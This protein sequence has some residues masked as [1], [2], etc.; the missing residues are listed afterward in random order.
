MI[1]ASTY[2]SHNTW[3]GQDCSTI[4]NNYI[5]LS[6][7]KI[8]AQTGHNPLEIN[9]PDIN[10]LNHP[11]DIISNESKYYTPHQFKNTYSDNKN[12]PYTT[13]I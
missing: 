10:I 5:V 7:P 4:N 11:N 2:V 1:I 9:D 3:D 12:I 6:K 13:S 8:Y